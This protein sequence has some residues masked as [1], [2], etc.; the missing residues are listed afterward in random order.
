MSARPSVSELLREPEGFLTRSDLAALGL[1]RAAVDACFRA[2]PTVH[3][4]DY[5]RPML[6]VRDFL[7]WR[8]ARTYRGDRVRAT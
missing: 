3:I 6:L 1:P 5:R 8:E 7:A 2:C 4:E